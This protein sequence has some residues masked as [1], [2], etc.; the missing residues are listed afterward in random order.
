MSIKDSLLVLAMIAIHYIERVNGDTG[1]REGIA[2]GKSFKATQEE[3][4]FLIAVGAARMAAA[5]HDAGKASAG[6]KSAREINQN[7]DKTPNKSANGE[8]DGNEEEDEDENLPVAADTLDLPAL[9][10]RATGL[11]LE[12]PGNISKAKLLAQVQEAEV[13]AAAE[14]DEADDSGLI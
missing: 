1:L 14:A 4:E 10:A 11:K 8:G 3:A 7:A 12:F 6:H 13:K 9:K 2:S 5:E